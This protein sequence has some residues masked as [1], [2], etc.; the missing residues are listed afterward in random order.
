MNSEY[1]QREFEAYR[2]DDADARAILDLAVEEKRSTS[3]EEDQHFDSLFE[4]AR[5]H[6]QRA[7]TLL[8]GDA[9]A[10][11]LA[12]AVRSQIGDPSDPDSGHAGP[13]H[14]GSDQALIAQIFETTRQ[15]KAGHE[16]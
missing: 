3:P 14:S 4:S 15:W 7:E 9:D 8:K 13:E 5:K 10:A 6:K 12:E 2:K 1:V 16:D 11:G